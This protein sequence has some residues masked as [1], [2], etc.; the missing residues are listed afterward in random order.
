MIVNIILVIISF[1]LFSFYYV[2]VKEINRI[3]YSAEKRNQWFDNLFLTVLLILF[4]SFFQT[5]RITFAYIYIIYFYI[6]IFSLFLDKK[7][8]FF[9]IGV[10]TIALIFAI[11]KFESLED[12]IFVYLKV[13]EPLIFLLIFKLS[14][15]NETSNKRSLII[16]IFA[17]IVL[18]T[19]SWVFIYDLSSPNVEEIFLEDLSFVV[20]YIALQAAFIF[21]IEKLYARYFNRENSYQKNQFNYFKSHLNSFITTNFLKNKNNSIAII[22]DISIKRKDNTKLEEKYFHEFFQSEVT[23]KYP[24]AIFFMKNLKTYALILSFNLDQV[25]EKFNLKEIYLGNDK[26]N[27]S[28]N[29]LL[30][31]LDKITNQFIDSF[32]LK[33]YGSIYGLETNDI[34]QLFKLNDFLK[35]KEFIPSYANNIIIYNQRLFNSYFQEKQALV[36]VFQKHKL[37]YKIYEKGFKNTINIYSEFTNDDRSQPL[38]KLETNYIE[39]FLI[40][41]QIKK[42]DTFINKSNIKIIVNVSYAWLF[43]NYEYF[44]KRLLQK[45]STNN[46]II[47]LDL[48]NINISLKKNDSFLDQLSSDFS[49]RVIDFETKN[50]QNLLKLDP[51]YISIPTKSKIVS[52]KTKLKEEKEKFLLKDNVF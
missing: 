10:V 20:I 6:T 5:E 44:K 45:A 4:L 9:S 23:K 46:I 11:L 40:N 31:N 1:I 30:S 26:K 41:E 21:Y 37:R 49:I 17:I 32:D 51:D 52:T 24:N 29:D 36:D 12:N 22:F 43:E 7:N 47:N 50:I 18:F 25:E 27:R 34:N 42:M 8:V 13:F 2:V 39:R 38:N 15:I 16:N 48:K 14:L 33:L 35:Q 19:T 28:A 3:N